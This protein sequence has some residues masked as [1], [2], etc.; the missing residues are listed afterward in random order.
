MSYFQLK[1]GFYLIKGSMNHVL[2]DLKNGNSMT[3]SNL[4]RK[5][6]ELVHVEKNMFD[7]LE[8]N[9]KLIL[10]TLIDSGIL[11]PSEKPAKPLNIR[12]APKINYST[13]SYLS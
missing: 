13:D 7:I 4:T 10:Q 11:I 12:T 9:E 6:I 2:Y 5:L 8:D 1:N 3:I